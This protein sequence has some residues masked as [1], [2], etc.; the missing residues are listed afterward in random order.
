MQKDEI[1]QDVAM[2]G[3]IFPKGNNLFLNNRQFC[4]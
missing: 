1:L 2:T 4:K 3:G